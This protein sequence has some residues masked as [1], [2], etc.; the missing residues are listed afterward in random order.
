MFA[1]YITHPQIEMDPSIP[2]PQWGLSAI[3]RRRSEA[4]AGLA[5]A[6]TLKRI[7]SSEEIKAIETAKI[8]AGP[9]ALKIEVGEQLGENDRSATGFLPPDEFEETAN[10]FFASPHDSIRGWERAIDAQDRIVTAIKRILDQ[11]NTELPIAFIGHGG[12]GTLLKC[13]LAGVPISRSQDQP[14]GGGNLFAFD[15]AKRSLKCDWTPME[16]WKG[17]DE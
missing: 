4:T 9:S 12:V 1:V 7:V 11:H 15:L 13:E 3:G 5:W 17:W 16:H 2:V 14:Y 8:L 6:S 10:Q